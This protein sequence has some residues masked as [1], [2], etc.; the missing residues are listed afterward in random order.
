MPLGK[1]GYH[2]IAVYL[3]TFSQHMW[4]F[5]YKMVGTVKTTIE[6]LSTITK[7]FIAPE[8]FMTDGRMHFNNNL[9]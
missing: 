3:D 8:T 1:G 2:T 7:H 9:V 5:K 6:V 4:A